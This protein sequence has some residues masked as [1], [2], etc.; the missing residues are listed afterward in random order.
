MGLRLG[1]G[2]DL[3][4]RFAGF[5]EETGQA[6]LSRGEILRHRLESAEQRPQLPDR[7]VD[8]GPPAREDGAELDQVL[9][10]RVLVG[11]LN[12]LR[13][14]SYSTGCGLAALSGSVEPSG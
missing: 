1:D 8:L 12:V 13:T 11:A 7:R 4:G 10:D 6:G 2:G 3:R 9:A 14:W 5:A